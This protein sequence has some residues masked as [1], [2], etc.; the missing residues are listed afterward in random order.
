MANYQ[1]FEVK[2]TNEDTT[3]L[4]KLNGKL[5]YVVGATNESNSSVS[6]V[7]EESA[8]L[9]GIPMSGTVSIPGQG[10]PCKQI[11]A[12]QGTTWVFYYIK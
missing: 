9:F 11:R 3:P 2:V 4:P 8:V 12:S 7:Y 1:D 5:Y 10:I 6:Y